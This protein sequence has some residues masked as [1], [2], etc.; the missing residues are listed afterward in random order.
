MHCLLISFMEKYTWHNSLRRTTTYLK[1]R[2]NPREEILKESHVDKH[3]CNLKA[4][5]LTIHY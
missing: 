4:T 2:I 3:N 1:S 5:K